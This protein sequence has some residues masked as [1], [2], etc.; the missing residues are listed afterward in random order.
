M[1][2][3]FV[4]SE[5]DLLSF[6]CPHCGCIEG[7]IYLSWGSCS[8]W[9]CECCNHECAVVENSVQ[10]IQIEIRDTDVHDL[11]GK[12][13]YNTKKKLDDRL[14]EDHGL[15]WILSHKFRVFELE[16]EWEKS[17]N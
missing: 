7:G 12:H 9:G 16:L 1:T 17:K 4:I 15:P 13:P 6:G 3:L 11:I 2:Q 10:D 5:L 14:V 8:L